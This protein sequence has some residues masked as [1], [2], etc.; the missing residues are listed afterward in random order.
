MD[1]CLQRSRVGLNQR[2]ADQRETALALALGP[3]DAAELEQ[4][5]GAA[6]AARQLVAQPL[7]LRA[8]PGCVA[9]EVERAR[10]LLPASKGRVA[11]GG[12]RH[13]DRERLQLRR[14]GRGTSRR[15]RVRGAIECR[16][17]LLVR[18]VRGQREV[19]R[20]LLRHI[21]TT[22]DEPVGAATH[23]RGRGLV[24]RRGKERVREANVAPGDL[25]DAGTLCRPQGIDVDERRRR[26]GED[27]SREQRL[28][29]R[30]GKTVEP[31][32]RQ[33]LHLPR[34]RQ[35]RAGRRTGP[36]ELAGDLERVERVAAAR[37]GDP[38]QDGPGERVAE[39]RLEDAVQGR[40]AR[41]RRPRAPRSDRVRPHA[42][43]WQAG[44]LRCGRRRA[45]RQ[46]DPRAGEPRIRAPPQSPDRATARRRRPAARAR[47]RG[48][49]AATADRPR[50]RVRPG[51]RLRRPPG[52]G[53][54]RALVAGRR[55]A[56][57][58]RRPQRR[59][60][61]PREPRTRG[62]P[63]RRSA[64][65]SG[66]SVPAARP[67]RLPPAT[68]SSSRCRPARRSRAREGPPALRRGR[69]RRAPA[70]SRARP[71]PRPARRQRAT[72]RVD[73]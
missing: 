42:R 21:E 52:A 17:G 10:E 18:T 35:R 40:D 23:R 63:P 12:R 49:G 11:V 27:G 41:A 32:S 61:D 5:F 55:E 20:L 65:P 26:A 19:P 66:P 6:L 56:R 37:R 15:D 7:E 45:R 69:N 2:V 67:G 59:P 1:A 38:D 13:A 72:G 60:A 71:A 8:R 47:P 53:R 31:A 51:F 50:R 73:T 54:R 24:H 57:R 4:G 58:R 39:A 29:G 48:R 43:T 34:H 62:S 46:V 3:E 22:G 33:R 25:D 36:V 64:E 70:P 30:V 16:G 14:R 68:A 44:R 9:R 28:E